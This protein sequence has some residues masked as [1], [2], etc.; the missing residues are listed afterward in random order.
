MPDYYAHSKKGVLP[1][2]WQPLDQHLKKVADFARK[3]ADD[4]GARDWG[5]L[6]QMSIKQEESQKM[7]ILCVYHVIFIICKE[8]MNLSQIESP[9]QSFD[10]SL[11]KR[12]AYE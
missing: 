1:S 3:F 5:C 7:W 4:F 12:E 2:E 9:N 10:C 8:S 11:I 6:V